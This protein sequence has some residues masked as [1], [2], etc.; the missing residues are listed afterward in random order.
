MRVKPIRDPIMTRWSARAGAPTC[1]ACEPRRPTGRVG[2]WLHRCLPERHPSCRSPTS[3]DPGEPS[4]QPS[5]SGYVVGPRDDAAAKA[6]RRRVGP[7]PSGQ[8]V[9]ERAPGQASTPITATETLRGPRAR[10]GVGP[11]SGVRRPRSG[12]HRFLDP[13]QREEQQASDERSQQA[14]G[15]HLTCPSRAVRRLPLTTLEGAAHDVA[16]GAVMGTLTR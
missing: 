12:W 6:P 8:V 4:D 1:L 15:G 16:C 2:R 13:S 3:M 14:E 9:V 10:E 7:R 11:H 5:H